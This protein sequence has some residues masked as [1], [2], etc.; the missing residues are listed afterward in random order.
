[1]KIPS[2]MAATLLACLP[3][4]ASESHSV[5]EF[6]TGESEKLDWRVVDNGVM[7]GLSQVK[8]EIG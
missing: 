6:T 8:R 1:M 4:A 5:A 2:V 7:G 3:A